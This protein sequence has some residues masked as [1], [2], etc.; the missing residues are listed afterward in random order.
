MG[1][2]D[3]TTSKNTIN[4][5]KRELLKCVSMTYPSKDSAKYTVLPGINNSYRSVLVYVS[6]LKHYTQDAL[7]IEKGGL[8][9][10]EMISPQSVNI[11]KS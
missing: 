3:T 11:S 6:V 9:F 7:S 5:G 8:I 10:A 2:G 4:S 1:R